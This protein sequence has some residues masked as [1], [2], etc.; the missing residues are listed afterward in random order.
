MVTDLPKCYAEGPRMR[1]AQEV[2]SVIGLVFADGDYVILHSHWHGL[3][4]NPGGEAVV[5]IDP[6]KNGKVVEH[7]DS[8]SSRSRRRLRTTTRC[9]DPLP[10]TTAA[11]ILA[12]NPA[13]KFRLI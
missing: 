8:S 2:E 11:A 6:S 9:S 4:D 10:T 7:W 3:W 5:D 12:F 13:V 1:D